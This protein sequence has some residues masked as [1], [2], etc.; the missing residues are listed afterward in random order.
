MTDTTYNGW[1]NYATWRVNLEIFD[2]WRMGEIAG[3]ED[4]DPE[5]ADSYDLGCILRNYVEELIDEQC[6]ADG[7]AHAYALAFLNDVNYPEIAHRMIQE[8]IEELKA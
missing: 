1:S 6:P 5:T 3:Y 2:N 4:Q 8:E 7:I